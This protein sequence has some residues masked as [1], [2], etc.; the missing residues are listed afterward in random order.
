MNISRK[1]M[2]GESDTDESEEEDPK[3]RKV[4]KKNNV[5]YV[6]EWV[7]DDD[8]LLGESANGNNSVPGEL[9]EITRFEKPEEAEQR[10]AAWA[11]RKER[12]REAKLEF[13]KAAHLTMVE[14]RSQTTGLNKVVAYG[15]NPQCLLGFVDYQREM[16]NPKVFTS[17]VEV[18]RKKASSDKKVYL[19]V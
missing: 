19:V 8:E 12:K 3:K 4:F 15:M 7:A 11:I 9:K 17:C 2:R 6:T 13:W 1:R 16:T 10:R 5:Y 14:I 18:K